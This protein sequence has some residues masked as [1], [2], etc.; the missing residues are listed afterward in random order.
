MFIANNQDSSLIHTIEFKSLG[1]ERGSL[2][3]LE[4]NKNVPFEIKRVYYIFDTQKGV[5]RGFHAHKN[6]QQVAVCVK[7]SCRMLFDNGLAK[8]SIVLDTPT[9]AVLIDRM[10]WHEMYDFTEDCVLMVLASDHYDESDYI[11]NY[12]DFIKASV[13]DDSSIK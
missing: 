4:G 2:I 10:Q 3:S 12:Q 11:R 6:L 9:K 13:K 8:E 5:A 1:D 7:G